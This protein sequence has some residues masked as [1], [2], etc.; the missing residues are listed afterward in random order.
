M[1]NTLFSSSPYIVLAWPGGGGVFWRIFWAGRWAD[2]YHRND[3]ELWAEKSGQIPFNCGLI[4]GII[5]IT[6]AVL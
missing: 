3:V 2:K 5:G 4:F 1:G 6:I